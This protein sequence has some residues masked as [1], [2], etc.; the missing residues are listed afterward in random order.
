VGD[1]F[2]SLSLECDLVCVHVLGDFFV[3]H[4]VVC[5]GEFRFTVTAVGMVFAC[6]KYPCTLQYLC[7]VFPLCVVC[8]VLCVLCVVCC[9]LCV[10]CVV[11]CV[12]CVLC[13]VCCVIM[14]CCWL[15]LLNLI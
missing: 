2:V 4:V 14:E 11:C 1:V 10:L 15:L 9:V 13:V 12:C 5:V 7:V 6:R 3:T 8:C